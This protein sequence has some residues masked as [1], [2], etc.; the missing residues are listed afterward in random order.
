MPSTHEPSHGAGQTRPVN[1]GKLL[2]CGAFE[3][4]LPQAAVKPN[5]STRD[6]VVNRATGSHA[7]S[8]VPVWQKGMP[9]SMHLA[10]CSAAF[11]STMWKLKIRSSHGWFDGRTI[12]R[13]LARVIYKAGRF[14]H[15]T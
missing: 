14:A 12:Q 11:H 7:V 9:Q 15:K 1:S 13:Q 8:S 10:P 3:R 4:F 6:Q 5:R 2:S